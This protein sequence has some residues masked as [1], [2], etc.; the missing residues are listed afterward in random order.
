VDTI[1]SS[2][3]V[4]LHVV[5]AVK[6]PSVD[7]NFQSMRSRD[8][9]LW[10]RGMKGRPSNSQC[11]VNRA[12]R[13]SS[14]AIEVGRASTIPP[15]TLTVYISPV[16]NKLFLILF[17]PICLR[18]IV[19]SRSKA[20]IAT[21]VSNC[22]TRN[23]CLAFLREVLDSL[24]FPHLWVFLANKHTEIVL[25]SMRGCGVLKL[26]SELMKQNSSKRFRLLL[27][28]FTK[29]KSNRGH[30]NALKTY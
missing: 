4:T 17:K 1:Q 10:P 21:T 19:N 30:Q 12:G 23:R 8:L 29:T 20:A 27:E 11:H 13:G 5:D 25:L 7:G 2:L 28:A 18:R 9:P 14:N 22:R 26:S 6:V 24:L 3:G 16:R 15:G